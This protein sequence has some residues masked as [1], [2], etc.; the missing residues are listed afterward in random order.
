VPSE[1]TAN[2][3]SV[4]IEIMQSNAIAFLAPSH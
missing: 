4:A 1:T 2:A 3:N